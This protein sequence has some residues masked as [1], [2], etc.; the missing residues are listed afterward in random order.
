MSEIFDL[1][2][3]ITHRLHRAGYI[4]YFA[5]GWV[6]DFVM[7]R[8]SKDIDI[9]TDAPSSAI[10]ELFPHTIPVGLAFGV[11]VVV[12]KGHHF[13]VATFR[14]DLD[15]QDG[16]HPQAI[17]LSNPEE[18]AKRR[19]FT[20]NGMFYD[21][22]K[23][24]I[25]DFVGGKSDIEKKI[26]KAIGNPYERFVEDR[27]RMIRAFRF[28]SRL[29]FSIEKETLEA[30]RLNAA[31]LFPAVAIERIWQEF[32][33]MVAYPHFDLAIIGMFEVGLLQIIFPDLQNVSL[34]EIRKYVLTYRAFPEKASAIFYLLQLFPNANIQQQL[35]IANK[36]KI[37]NKERESVCYVGKLYSFIK[38]ELQG[39][40]QELFDWAHA[41]AEHDSIFY[42]KIALVTFDVHLRETLLKK[43][44]ELFQN[45]ALHIERI[46]ER[47]PLISSQFLFEK[48][49]KPGKKMGR[50]L[51]EA[52][53]IT[54]NENLFDKE[55][56]F[57]QLQNHSVWKDQNAS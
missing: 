10:I 43:Y 44:Q 47:K 41:F 16:R 18:D 14:K 52:E 32:T 30:I 17:E 20:I 51:K 25:L 27:L 1:A 33:K 23:E 36:F 54:I 2:K 28:A 3:T 31:Q 38:N 48:G 19:D 46:R 24:E 12:Y 34:Q 8:P 21:P 9:A 11:V 7:N 15:Y 55:Q 42:L 57:A 49:I 26:V 37:S 53:R 35:E 13:E 5:G 40:Q 29:S 50:L 56:I 45:L 39:N 22:I 4:A 6:R